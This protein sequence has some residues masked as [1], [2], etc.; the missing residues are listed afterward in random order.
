MFHRDAIALALQKDVRVQ[1]DYEL[2]GLSSLLVADAIYGVKEMRD[3][4]GVW[5]KR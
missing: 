3:T 1:S 4:F 5:V 2:R